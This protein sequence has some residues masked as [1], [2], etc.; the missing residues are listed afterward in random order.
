MHI[1]LLKI[2]PIRKDLRGVADA[3][4]HHV[5]FV[6]KFVN[7][8]HLNVQRIVSFGDYK[9]PLAKGLLDRDQRRASLPHGLFKFP[10]ELIARAV[11]NGV[12]NDCHDDK[13]L[14]AVRRNWCCSWNEFFHAA[15]VSLWRSCSST[16]WCFLNLQN[17]IDQVTRFVSSTRLVRVKDE[18]LL[19]RKS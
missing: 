8:P 11:S 19:C 9:R 5:F 17:A 4:V 3:D 16:W 13:R 1:L 7:T 14:K 12:R 2:F 6:P 15:A 18:I 10:I